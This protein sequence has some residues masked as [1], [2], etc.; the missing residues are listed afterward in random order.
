MA[1]T[2]DKGYAPIKPPKKSGHHVESNLTIAP[3]DL[4]KEMVDMINLILNVAKELPT[5]LLAPLPRFLKAKCCAKA[6][7]MPGYDPAM[8]WPP[9]TVLGHS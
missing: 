4:A 5:W 8:Y 9:W 7:H 6:S 2:K 3:G 1:R